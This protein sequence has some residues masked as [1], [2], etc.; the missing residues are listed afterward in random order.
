MEHAIDNFLPR[1]ALWNTQWFNKPK[2]H[3]LLH[4]LLHIQKFGPP[5][6]CATESFESYNYVICTHT[7][8]TQTDKLQVWI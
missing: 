5:I 8:F 3:I 6:L 7:V 2:F 1:T 4:I